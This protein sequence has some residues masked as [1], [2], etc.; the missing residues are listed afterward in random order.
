ML[1]LQMTLCF[2]AVTTLHLQQELVPLQ[3]YLL[4]ASLPWPC[5]RHSSSAAVS[6]N[7]SSNSN[8][9]NS[10]C[11]SSTKAPLSLRTGVPLLLQRLV[12]HTSTPTATVTA[13]TSGGHSDTAQQQQQLLCAAR[14]GQ[15]FAGL[16][17]GVLLTS[18]RSAAEWAEIL[19]KMG[20]TG[21]QS[22]SFYAT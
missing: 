17:V 8:N 4:P 2:V 22:M 7:G 3:P 1:T 10:S 19:N 15:V 5:P 11:S 20:A 9:S 18:A 13:S 12:P 21:K 16:T 6:S 14:A